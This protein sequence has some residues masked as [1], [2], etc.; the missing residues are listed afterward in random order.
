MPLHIFACDDVRVDSAII[1][2][3]SLAN[4]LTARAV[5]GA[6]AILAGMA[7]LPATVEKPR[8]AGDLAWQESQ[9]PVG[10]GHNLL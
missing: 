1:S 3:D 8:A 7:D 9:V 2:L 4:M 6:S 10:R 5:A